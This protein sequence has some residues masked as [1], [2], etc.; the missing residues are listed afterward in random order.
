MLL[1]NSIICRG[2]MVLKHIKN[3]IISNGMVFGFV[4][5]WLLSR[6]F[7]EHA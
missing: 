7:G 4:R 2:Q 5:K 3:E 6:T 1:H